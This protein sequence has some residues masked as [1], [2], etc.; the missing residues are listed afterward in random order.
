MEALQ[1]PILLRAGLAPWLALANES[2]EQKSPLSLKR[3]F[4]WRSCPGSVETNLSSIHE[5][6]VLTPGFDQWVKYLVWLQAVS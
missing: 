5:D 1:S 2:L 4:D 6:A 3:S